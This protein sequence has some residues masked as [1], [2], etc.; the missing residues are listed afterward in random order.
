MLKSRH[1]E[2]NQLSGRQKQRVAQTIFVVIHDPEFALH[3]D[4]I[5]AKEDG[6][7]IG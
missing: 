3:A 5:V 4:R 1:L 7:I 2:V 6:K